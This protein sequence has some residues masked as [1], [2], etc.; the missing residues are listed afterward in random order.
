MVAKIFKL[1]QSVLTPSLY[2]SLELSVLEL[3]HPANLNDLA[4]RIL[5]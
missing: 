5:F 3:T 1:D 2:D 4:V